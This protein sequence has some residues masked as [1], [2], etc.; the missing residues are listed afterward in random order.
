MPKV[1]NGE[2]A[3]IVGTVVQGNSH[4]Y[5]LVVAIKRL[6]VLEERSRGGGLVPELPASTSAIDAIFVM[7]MT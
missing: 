2:L 6:H 3:V 7:D 4:M 1:V 5:T